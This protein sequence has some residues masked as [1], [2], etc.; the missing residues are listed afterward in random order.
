M[1]SAILAGDVDI[2][3]V[4]PDHPNEGRVE[5]QDLHIRDSKSTSCIPI[6][7]SEDVTSAVPNIA[8]E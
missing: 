2:G 8:P 4:G 3:C 5:P 1:D 6:Q 7:P